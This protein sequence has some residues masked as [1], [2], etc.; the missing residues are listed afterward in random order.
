MLN[1]GNPTAGKD[2]FENSKYPVGTQPDPNY[3]LARVYNAG[4]HA[5]A[6]GALE[7]KGGAFG[8]ALNGKLLYLRYSSGSDIVSFDAAPDGTLSN[9]T[10][11]LNGTTNM[12]APLDMAED[13]ATGNL[14]VTEMTQDG[15]HSAIKLL[16]PQGGGGG[17]VASA[18][19]RLVFSGPTGSTSATRNAVVK[20]TG[21]D[22]LVVTGATLGGAAPGSSRSRR[23]RRTRSPSPR[24][25]P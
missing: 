1:N 8:G 16:K 23:A 24:A 10:F 14:Y 13:L 19:D 18:T 6:N 17:P 4:L 3:D 7:Y 5:S 25:R 11:G 20:N 22:D 21:I 12:Q 15:S 9:Q 2:K